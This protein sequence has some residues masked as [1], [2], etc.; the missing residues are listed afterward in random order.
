MSELSPSA[1]KRLK[2]WEKIRLFRAEV[3]TLRGTL[4]ALPESRMLENFASENLALKEKI[5]SLT[6]RLESQYGQMRQ[7]EKQ[8]KELDTICRGLALRWHAAEH[9]AAELES[10]SPIPGIRIVAHKPIP[11]AWRVTT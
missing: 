3:R 1:G 5:K 6:T 4:A 10:Y 9:R 8:I 11:E 2:H 7:Q